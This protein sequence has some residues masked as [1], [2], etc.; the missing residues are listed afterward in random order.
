MFIESEPLPGRT[1]PY[2]PAPG[3]TGGR[4]NSDVTEVRFDALYQLARCRTPWHTQPLSGVPRI[5][6]YPAST[7]FHYIVGDDWGSKAIT[8]GCR[9][10]WQA[11]GGS[12]RRQ[13]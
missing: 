8:A 11:I 2:K 6:S 9:S 7:T 13:I 10:A 4:H 1:H 3:D 12:N 5:P